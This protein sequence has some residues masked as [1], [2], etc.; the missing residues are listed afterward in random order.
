MDNTG[1]YVRSHPLR[2]TRM[3]SLQ[4]WMPQWI[5]YRGYTTSNG[6]DFAAVSVKCNQNKAMPVTAWFLPQIP[7]INAFT[8]QALRG[9][10]FHSHVFPPQS[11]GGGDS[12]CQILF[13]W[14]LDA[15]IKADLGS[16]AWME[17][18]SAHKLPHL[19]ISSCHPHL[20]SPA[21]VSHLAFL[22]LADDGDIFLLFRLFPTFP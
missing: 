12:P 20:L 22:F 14:P 4:T 8:I 15:K 11:S 2:S 18:I 17:S 19:S 5:H 10:W 16:Q 6:L 9:R 21:L 1:L 3:P 13:D 7:H